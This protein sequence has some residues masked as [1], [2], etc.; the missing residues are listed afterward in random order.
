MPKHKRK[1]SEDFS[2]NSTGG[3]E[4][5][6]VKIVGLEQEEQD[7]SNLPSSQSLAAIRIRTLRHDADTRAEKLGAQAEID[8][9]ISELEGWR[10]E[11]E[12]TIAFL[13]ARR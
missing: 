11:I 9:T 5:V 6:S 2:S 13:K 1:H 4:S 12:R 7:A 3:E 8:R 10:D